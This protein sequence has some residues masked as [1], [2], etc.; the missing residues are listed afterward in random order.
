MIFTQK[1]F[2]SA[3]HSIQ[4]PLQGTSAALLCALFHSSGTS[5]CGSGL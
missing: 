4:D 2:Q 3:V 1:S 5:H